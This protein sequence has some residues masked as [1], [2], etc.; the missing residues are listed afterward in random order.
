MIQNLV[1]IFDIII[2]FHIYAVYYIASFLYARNQNI[3]SYQLLLQIMMKYFLLSLS[4]HKYGPHTTGFW[5]KC[6]SCAQEYHII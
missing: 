6:S 1:N 2:H 4:V 3:F 5:D